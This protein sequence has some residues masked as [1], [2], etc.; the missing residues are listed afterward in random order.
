MEFNHVHINCFNKLVFFT[1]FGEE[2]DSRFIS[3]NQ[4]EEFLKDEVF[5][6]FASL[7]VKIKDEIVD[8]PV[9]HEFSD[10]F[11]DDISNFPPE[12]EVAFAI[13]L[14]PDTRP[15]SMAS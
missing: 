2:E 8:L 5:A 4:V 3:A 1:K 12:R 7:K 13:D 9:V 10:V 6:I 14:V 11:L 15:V